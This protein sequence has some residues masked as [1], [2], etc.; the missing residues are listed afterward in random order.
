MDTA[1]T[2]PDLIADGDKSSEEFGLKVAKF[3]SNEWFYPHFVD[4]RFYN[5]NQ[6]ISQ[7]RELMTD[8][9]DYRMFMNI[10]GVNEDVSSITLDWSFLQLIPKYVNIITNSFTPDMYKA[11]I[12]AVD[13]YSAGE[14]FNYQKR[15]LG[16]M[17]TY[18]D[19]VAMS[20]AL[21]VDVSNKGYVPQNMQEFNLHTQLDYRQRHVI[22]MRVALQQV[23]NMNDWPELLRQVLED[24][25]VSRYGVVHHSFHPEKGIVLQ[26]VMPERFIHSKNA[27]LKRNF[28]NS[29]YFGHVEYMTISEIRVV[30]NN[31]FTE[32]EY[33]RMASQYGKVFGNPAFDVNSS[34]VYDDFILPVL[35]FSIKSDKQNVYK[36]KY[37]RAGKGYK[38][39]KKDNDWEASDKAHNYER[40]TERYTTWYSGINIVDTDFLINYGEMTDLVRPKSNLR[41]AYPPYAVY[42][43]SS[44]SPVERMEP[45][46]IQLQVIHLK[47]Q[48]LVS[49]L[50]PDG[51]AVDI[52]ALTN[53]DL[54]TGQYLNP[55]DQV[56][57]YNEKGNLLYSGHA[58]DGSLNREPIRP[59]SYNTTQ[60]LTELIG[61]YNHYIQQIR[62]VVGINEIREGSNP[63]SKALVGVYKIALEQSN[64][65]TKHIL[66]AIIS[67]IGDI[68]KAV[69]LRVQDL[70]IYKELYD[71]LIAVIGEESAQA[72]MEDRNKFYWDMAI[73]ISINPDL[74]EMENFQRRLDLAMQKGLITMDDVIDIE[75]VKDIELASQVLKYKI[76]QRILQAKQD[77]IDINKANVD[78]QA[79]A[80]IKKKQMEA[81]I[82]AQE[83]QEQ[84]SILMFK[85]K[86][87]A[88]T[89]N[90]EYQK[91]FKMEA[92]KHDN[93][94]SEIYL[95]GLMGQKASAESTKTQKDLVDKRSE[96]ESALIEQRKGNAGKQSFTEGQGQSVLGDM[97]PELAQ[98][99]VDPEALAQQSIQ[100]ANQI[101]NQEGAQGQPGA[102][103][104][105]PQQ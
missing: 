23:F 12:E 80:D 7:L 19:S 43:L 100:G 31:K 14:K 86:L 87:E 61:L 70:V 103:P 76:K 55:I 93:K 71:S 13:K 2:F 40:V 89:K 48:Q 64:T 18:D 94:M 54:G 39:I 53:V 35:Y 3:I 60:K 38:L 97:F 67:I 98:M 30:S 51:I 37:N 27:D 92:F 85:T 6:R 62:D 15:V 17:L 32:D 21:G 95:T 22:A 75:Q 11:N 50:K 73:T 102:V 90:A 69:I 77:Q 99:G 88:M 44:S 20:H 82:K 28:K 79:E 74:S 84:Q 9:M 45:L 8:G 83:L 78:A 5:N 10:M 63:G 57:I 46:V 34:A 59:L 104:P 101:E 105:Q 41:E 24:I 16:N 25:C 68:S 72:L 33:K 26:R 47:L 66:D 42:K 65:A 52:D 91:D 96:N 56:R 58:L 36:K 1:L 4:G 49:S 81:Q 29:H